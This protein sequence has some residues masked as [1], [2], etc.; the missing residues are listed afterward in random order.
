M[1]DDFS[2]QAVTVAILRMFRPDGYLDICTIDQC[3]KV[4]NVIPPREDYE[5]LRVLHC[6][7]WKEMPTVVREEAVRRIMAL[8]RHGGIEVSASAFEAPTAEVKTRSF[9]GRL[10]GSGQPQ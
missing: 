3:L 7:H 1:S 10:L 8:F 6:V 9:F 5:A 4:V 2:R